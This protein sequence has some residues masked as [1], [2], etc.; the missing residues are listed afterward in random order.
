MLFPHL[1]KELEEKKLSNINSIKG[2]SMP[3]AFS[4]GFIACKTLGIK[5]VNPY[6]DKRKSDGGPT[7][8]TG[9]HNSW[10]KGWELYKKI[11]SDYFGV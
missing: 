9:F 1:E 5:A 8:S 3:G 6:K 2:K 11:V 10:N 4:R 7:F